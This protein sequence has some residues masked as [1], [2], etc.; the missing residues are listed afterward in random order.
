[1]DSNL[2]R[3]VDGSVDIS[4]F[5]RR[6]IYATYDDINRDN[7]IDALNEAL[8]VHTV[9]MMEEEFLYW[10]R[11]GVQPILGRKKEIRP[12]INHRVVESHAD[13]IVN[14]K[15]GWFLTQPA[16]Y[17]SRSQD[18]DVLKA[19]DK[20]N[21]YLYRSG[22]HHADCQIVDWF[23]TVGKAILYVKPE[24]STDKPYSCYALDP[25]SAFVVRSTEADRHPVMGVN[26]VVVGDRVKFDV[27]TEKYAFKVDGGVM[28][29]LIT[30]TPILNASAVTI[31]EM[32]PNALKR[33]PIIEYRYNSV[34][35]GAFEAVI[36]LLDAINEVQSNRLDG[37]DQFIQSLLV[38][39]NCTPGEDANGNEVSPQMIRDAGAIYL[40]NAGEHKADLKEIASQLDQSQTQVLVDYLYQQV[41]TICG[42]PTTTKGGASTSDTGSAVLARDG[43]YQADVSARNTED[44][45]MESNAYFDDIMLDILRRKGLV[46]VKSTDLNL[47]IVRNETVNIQSKAQ[48]YRTLVDGGFHPILAMKK[49]GVSNDPDKDFDMSKE[50]LA[51]KI[52]DPSAQTTFAVGTGGVMQPDG[53]GAGAQN[54]AQ[55]QNGSNGFAGGNPDG[56]DNPNSAPMGAHWVR[57]YWKT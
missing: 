6:D 50:Y 21:E 23:H 28:G 18:E 49:S 17:V 8:A 46:D 36:P 37:I 32:K 33:I 3:F 19:V 7:L 48:A 22:R 42:M 52:G 1:M 57:G 54:G 4:L 27:Y 20:V 40:K 47:Q 5:G 2:V 55:P 12:E 30:N 11:R 25:R 39:Y 51:M 56:P 38:F 41:L 45:W 31:T 29:K 24:D 26:M 9:N 43:W 53:G 34:N 44:L 16:V 14:F 35:M 10:Y 13:E 15:D